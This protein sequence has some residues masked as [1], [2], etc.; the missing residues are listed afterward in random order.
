MPCRIKKKTHEKKYV[1]IRLECIQ[2]SS[3]AA[4]KK[5]QPTRKLFSC[6]ERIPFQLPS[7]NLYYYPHRSMAAFVKG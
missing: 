6:N 1:L 4:G 2:A 7:V 3:Y 5:W